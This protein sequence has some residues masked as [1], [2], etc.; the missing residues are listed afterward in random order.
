[1]N[2]YETITKTMLELLDQGVVPWKR[3]WTGGRIGRPRNLCTNIPYRGVNV[4]M[5]AATALAKGYTSPYWV[6]YKQTQYDVHFMHVRE[7]EHGTPIVRAITSAEP[8]P[9]DGDEGAAEEPRRWRGMRHYIVFNTEQYA[10]SDHARQTI[11]TFYTPPLTW[12]PVAEA[13]R[14]V[15]GMP[16]VP[17]IRIDGT[18]VP[19]YNLKTDTVHMLDRTRFPSAGGFYESLFHELTHSTGHA[20]RLNRSTIAEAKSMLSSEWYGKEEL[21][22]EWGATY[23]LALCGLDQGTQ[24]NTAAYLRYWRNQIA[25]D[26][27]ILVQAAAQAQKACDFILNEQAAVVQIGGNERQLAA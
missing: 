19:Y 12:D 14:L 24:E 3:P 21:I 4:M 13:E 22:A 27:T 6:T 23:L 17:L 7:G 2:A 20:Q 15:T 1:M 16:Q 8:M 26:E 10:M 9:D 5:L 25:A 18:P 11:A